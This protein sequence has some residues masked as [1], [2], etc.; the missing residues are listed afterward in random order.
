MQI[1]DR[2]HVLCSSFVSSTLQYAQIFY[3]IVI[4]SSLQINLDF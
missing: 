1:R 4:Y 3:Q 2:K